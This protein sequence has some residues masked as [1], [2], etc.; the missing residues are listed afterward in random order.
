MDFN[1]TNFYRINKIL[2]NEDFQQPSKGKRSPPPS[3][4]Q[5]EGFRFHFEFTRGENCATSCDDAFEEILSACTGQSTMKYKGSLDTGCGTYSYFIKDPPP[6]PPPKAATCKPLGTPEG[7]E[8]WGPH[9]GY[10][11]SVLQAGAHQFC[12]DGY[13]WIAKPKDEFSANNYF[14]FDTKRTDPN[15]NLPTYCFGMS[16]GDF[17]QWSPPTMYD[18]DG[19]DSKVMLLVIPAKDQNGCKPLKDYPLKT[20][21]D[22]TEV[23]D[24]VANDCMTGNDEDD[25]TG[26]FYLDK[27]DSGCWEWWVWGVY[28]ICEYKSLI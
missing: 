9:K 10:S 8:G 22:C 27:S 20:G 13:D 23:F 7:W 2:T 11:K 14:W 6:P 25:D 18:C 4:T 12:N 17:D 3:G 16:Y 15:N 28:S 5:Y 1:C 19:Q 26:G 24:K 21:S